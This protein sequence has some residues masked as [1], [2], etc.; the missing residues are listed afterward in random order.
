MHFRVR[1]NVVQ[2]VRTNYDA[3]GK[4]PKATVASGASH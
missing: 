4:E 3:E 2:L 1:K